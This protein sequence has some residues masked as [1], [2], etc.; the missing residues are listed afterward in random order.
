MPE[1]ALSEFFQVT[2]IRGTTINGFIGP[3]LSLPTVVILSLSVGAVV[4]PLYLRRGYAPGAAVRGAAVCAFLLTGLV[5]AVQADHQWLSWLRGDRVLFEGKGFEEKMAVI[6]G[7]LYPAA[8][9]LKEVLGSSDYA[10]YADNDSN[11]SL[12][13]LAKKLQYHLL[14]RRNRAAAPFI[15]V[16]FDSTV[17]YDERTGLFRGKDGKVLSAGTVHTF[18]EGFYVLRVRG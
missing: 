8:T 4:I 3:L 16:L 18:E 7:P 10:L 9:K 2:P 11:E 12:P 5:Y 6:D 13:Y 14:P 15:V 17:R 1:L